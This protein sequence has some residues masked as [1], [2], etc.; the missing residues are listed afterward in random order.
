M[1]GIEDRRSDP[2]SGPRGRISRS[3]ASPPAPGRV[4]RRV[5][6]AVGLGVVDRA[7][8]ALRGGGGRDRPPLAP[9]AE[10]GG[11]RGDAFEDW[12]DI[13]RGAH[14]EQHRGG[15]AALAGAA[16]ERGD[17]VLDRDV[18]RIHELNQEQQGD[19]PA[20]MV[21]VMVRTGCSSMSGPSGMLGALP[22]TMS[23]T[24]VSPMARPMPSITAMTIPER[25]AG[26]TTR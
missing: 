23:T 10:A 26:T 24:I 5:P 17:D 25:A 3:P 13:A 21:A 14:R 6:R 2:P 7:R 22:V 20:A 1:D 4:R 15:H 12:M 16:G 8:D 9:Q 11:A 18:G 19:S